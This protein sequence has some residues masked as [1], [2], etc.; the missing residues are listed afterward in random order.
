MANVT[1]TLISNRAATPRVANDPF[2]NGVLKTTGVGICAVTT[3]EDANDILRFVM[4]PANA[5]VRN[6]RLSCTAVAV[7]GALNIGVYRSA[8]DGGA[9]VDADLFASAVV[10]TTALSNSDVT[11]ESGEY[12]L[13]ESNMPLWKAAGLTSAPASGWLVVAGTISTDMG[14][15]GT[16]GVSVSYV[17]GGA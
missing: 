15:T 11:Y 7:G 9:V 14:G 12:T 8:D 2:S 6:V 1:S 10:V 17:D 3:A 5:V 16:I 4:V 13:A